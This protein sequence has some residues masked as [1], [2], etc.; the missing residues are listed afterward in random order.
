MQRLPSCRTLIT[1]QNFAYQPYEGMAGLKISD[2]IGKVGSAANTHNSAAVASTSMQSIPRLQNR[3]AGKSGR[4]SSGATTGSQ[5]GYVP[6][7]IRALT[8]ESSSG[9]ASQPRSAQ[10]AVGKLID[11]DDAKTVSSAS[12]PYE[13]AWSSTGT[14]GPWSAVD[15]R[16][17]NALY[18]PHRA[19][20]EPTCSVAGPVPGPSPAYSQPISKRGWARPVSTPAQAAGS[21]KR[22]IE[23]DNLL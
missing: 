14:L 18:E 21:R 1:L 5:S 6:P 9:P 19:L 7:H 10:S 13:D 16:R 15:T 2:K 23:T 17:R 8:K 11:V 4:V 12:N 22:M 3:S 20:D